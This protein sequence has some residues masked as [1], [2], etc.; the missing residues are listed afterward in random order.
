[1][2]LE[3]PNLIAW[4]NGHTHINTV[5]AHARDDGKGGFWEIT[6]ASCID[7][8]QQQQLLEVV[9]NRDGTL[10]IFTT[11]LDHA[12]RRGSGVRATSRRTG[13]PSLSRELASNDWIANPLMRL[14]SPLDRN[15]ELLL[16]APFD[17]EVITDA[18]LEKETMARKARLVANERGGAA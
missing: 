11:T 13:W 17:L 6:A 18:A 4:S 9:D 5:V 2:L 15:V 16:P 10:S 8:P 3:Y 14:G 12:S 7:Y 1:M